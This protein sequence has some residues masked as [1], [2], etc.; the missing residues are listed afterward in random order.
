MAAREGEG[1]G[2]IC[3]TIRSRILSYAICGMLTYAHVCSR[4][5][6]YAHVCSHMLTYA[7]VCS[8]MLTY[9]HVCCRE[10]I[11]Y[12]RCTLGGDLAGTRRE[13]V[14]SLL[15]LL[16]QKVQILT[17]LLP[18]GKRMTLSSHQTPRESRAFFWRSSSGQTSRCLSGFATALMIAIGQRRTAFLT[19]PSTVSCR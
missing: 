2:A 18:G 12:R 13:L 19:L 1:C 8:R 7:H 16:V 3:D 5:L 10:A 14:L 17:L 11:Q 15:A 9:A 4:M 6:L